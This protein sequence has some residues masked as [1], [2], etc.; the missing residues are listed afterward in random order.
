VGP[1]QGL[2]DKLK[3]RLK[4]DDHLRQPDFSS[5]L[6]LESENMAPVAG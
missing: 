5:E 3:D 1:R 4:R 6:G 2:A